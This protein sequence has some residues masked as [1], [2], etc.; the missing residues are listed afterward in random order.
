MRQVLP[1]TRTRAGL[2][3]DLPPRGLYDPAR[4][5]VDPLIVA[6]VAAAAGGI[7]AGTL[8]ERGK[9]IWRG[10][11]RSLARLMKFRVDRQYNTTMSTYVMLPWQNGVAV[12]DFPSARRD[13]SLAEIEDRLDTAITRLEQ[14]WP[15]IERLLTERMTT[16]R[17]FW[18]VHNPP[19]GPFITWISQPENAP[20]LSPDGRLIYMTPVGQ[21]NWHS[22][23]QA[24]P[25]PTLFHIVSEYQRGDN[26]PTD[27]TFE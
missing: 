11:K 4:A 18:H 16:D 12:I 14:R 3:E 19:S 6:A 2:R 26:A 5:A 23:Q 15:E 10:L 17:P 24:A 7:P 8:Q 21:M 22:W 9:D 13:D 27:F 1:P 20:V 25:R